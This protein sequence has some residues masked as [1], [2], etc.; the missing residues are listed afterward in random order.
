MRKI[1]V[2]IVLLCSCAKA[3]VAKP[4]GAGSATAAGRTGQGLVAGGVV[5][6]SA[7]YKLIGTLTSGQGTTSSTHYE[8]RGGVIGATQ[9]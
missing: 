7:R 3:E 9:P 2:S 6:K 1:A 5:A 8:Q 4:D